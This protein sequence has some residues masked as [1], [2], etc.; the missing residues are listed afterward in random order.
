MPAFDCDPSTCTSSWSRRPRDHLAPALPLAAMA[1]P[2]AAEHIACGGPR[3]VEEVAVR[4]IRR[5][6]IDSD[7]IYVVDLASPFRLFKVGAWV[8]GR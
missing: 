6:D 4:H 1:L 7:S 5:H 8:S 3:G 2:R